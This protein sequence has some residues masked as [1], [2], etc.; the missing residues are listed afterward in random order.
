MCSIIDSLAALTAPEGDLVILVKPQFE[1][2]HSDASRGRGVIRDPRLWRSALGTVE[3]AAVDRGLRVV[4][5]T[6]SA[7]RGAQGNTEFFVRF[8]HAGTFD[9]SGGVAPVD[10]GWIDRLVASTE[11]SDGGPGGTDG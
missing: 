11:G 3:R 10:A 8:R 9:P 5:A 7:V 4:G 2:A 6:V 1:V